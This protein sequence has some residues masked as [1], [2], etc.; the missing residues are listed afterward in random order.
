MQAAYVCVGGLFSLAYTDI[1]LVSEGASNICTVKAKTCSTPK[2]MSHM[3]R[4]C[5]SMLLKP[6][7]IG[8][9]YIQQRLGH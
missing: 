8:T 4:A 3:H 7:R 6:P 1:G 2:A 9:A 5:H